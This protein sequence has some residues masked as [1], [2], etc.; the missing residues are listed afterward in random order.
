MKHVILTLVTIFATA[1]MAGCYPT[2][3]I[4]KLSTN[5][6][7]N[8][9]TDDKGEEDSGLVKYS[10]IFTPGESGY[11]IFRIPAVVKT[12]KGTLLCFAE[13]RVEGRSDF[14][15][16][17]IVLKRSE[18]GGATWGNLIVVQD[19]GSDR[20]CNPVPVAL[21]DGKVLLL[22]CWN[23]D[24][25]SA[26]QKVF[27]IFSDNDGK[28][29]GS[30]TEITQQILR[31]GESNYMT[32][33]VHGIVKKYAPAAG[34]IIIPARCKS[35]Y[36]KPSHVIYSDDEGKTWKKG[37]SASYDHENENTVTELAD[38]SLLMNMRDYNTSGTS[39][40]RYDAVSTDGGLTFGS[41]RKTD[42]VEPKNGCQG[43]LLTCKDDTSKGIS[44]VLFSN[45]S[46]ASSR[47]HGSVKLSSDNGKTWTR[48]YR[49]TD[50]SGDGMY[51][52]YSDLVLL[53]NGNA[54]GIIY[55]A[56]YNNG[57]GIVF[58]SIN[59]SSITDEYKY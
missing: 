22:Y 33:P 12:A 2:E 3:D 41:T 23:K 34:R 28:N 19:S 21:N 56:G 24:G 40:F 4:E 32:G 17:D 44:T 46:H 49:Y 47:R 29:W 31:D 13:G 39:W 5:G 36:D 45:P 6:K 55:E 25:A 50:E 43:A 58:K 7:Q 14:G 54:V 30:P 15:N 18:D 51:S 42:L 8:E 27:T 20:C 26:T 35:P 37:A 59:I 53:N 38:G 16:I 57:A 11:A 52:A 1:A 48:M 10:T 9:K